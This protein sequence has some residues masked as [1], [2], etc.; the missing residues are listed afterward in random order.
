MWLILCSFLDP[1][2]FNHDFRGGGRGRGRGRGGRGGNR[3]DNQGMIFWLIMRGTLIAKNLGHGVITQYLKSSVVP[4][5]TFANVN[6]MN[7]VSIFGTGR[8]GSKGIM[9]GWKCIFKEW[10]SLLF[11]ADCDRVRRMLAFFQGKGFDICHM[12]NTRILDS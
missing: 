5:R 1:L 8:T 2:G 6:T 11:T 9:S 10:V 4:G 3:N 12:L 7:L